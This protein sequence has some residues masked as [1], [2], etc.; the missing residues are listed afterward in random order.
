MVVDHLSTITLND[1][2]EDILHEKL[3]EVGIEVVHLERADPTLEDVFH[4]LAT[5]RVSK[6]QDDAG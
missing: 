5:S 1:V 6:G 2:N 3:A 4:S